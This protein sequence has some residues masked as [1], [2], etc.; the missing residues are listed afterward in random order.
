VEVERTRGGGRER[1]LGGE[2]ILCGGAINSP[3]LLQLSGVGP[4]AALAEAGVATVADVP[5]VGDH[6]QDHLEVYLQHACTQPVSM[7]PM[8]AMWRR[9]IIGLE[10]LFRR[11]PGATN[12]FEAGGFIRSN[13]EV[14]YP[15]V[16]FHFLPIAIRY[17]G[18]VPEGGGGHGYQVHVG[19]MYSDARGTV[20]LKSRDPRVKPAL[21]FNYLS[22]ETDRREWVETIRA[23]REILAQPAF[24]PFDGGELSP[25]PAVETDQEILDWVARDAETALHPSCT[26]RL[27][28][29]E[30]GAIHPDTFRVYGVDGLRVVDASS[31]RYVTNGNIYAPVMMLAEK[32]ADAILG[33][34]PLPPEIVPVYRH[35]GGAA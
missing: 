11:G 5:A 29:D 35:G 22:T 7:A 16:M 28:S 9:P 21:R 25:G 3:Q 33:N 31:M 24:A 32:A 27:G 15:N 2:V 12:H 30:S 6:L 34:E 1:I 17:D 13:D 26:A 19:P 14:A 20:R 18:T 23:A 10:W 8:L 4:V